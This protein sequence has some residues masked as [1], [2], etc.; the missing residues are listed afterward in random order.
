MAYRDSVYLNGAKFLQELRETVGDQA[1]N[2]FIKAYVAEHRYEIATAEDF[3][4]ILSQHSDAEL[5]PLLN[6]YF[7]NTTEMP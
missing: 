5:A 1:F 3:W 4:R 6:T 7:A 2:D